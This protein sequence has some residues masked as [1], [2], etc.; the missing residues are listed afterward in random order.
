MTKYNVPAKR[1]SFKSM[2]V[3]AGDEPAQ[4]GETWPQS[5]RVVMPAPVTEIK[6]PR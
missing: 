1:V 6:C 3:L 4:A 2:A 5:E